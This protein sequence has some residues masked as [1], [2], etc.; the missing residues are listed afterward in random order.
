[1]NSITLPDI[2]TVRRSGPTMLLSLLSSA[3]NVA[4]VSVSVCESAVYVPVSAYPVAPTPAPPALASG[5]DIERALCMRADADRDDTDTEDIDIELEL[6][7]VI[8]ASVRTLLL[9]CIIS[10]SSTVSRAKNYIIIGVVS[11]ISLYNC[12]YYCDTCQE[13]ED[14]GGQSSGPEPA[15]KTLRM[16]VCMY[17]CVCKYVCVSV[18][19]YVCMC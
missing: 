6:R 12:V 16:Y 18:C 14:D 9:S 15:K 17:V 4:L 8:A 19:V 5:I 10:S 7:A 13:C 1:M 3:S 2:S 11:V